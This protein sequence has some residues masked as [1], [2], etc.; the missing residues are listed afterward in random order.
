MSKQL[1]V[2]IWSDIACPWCYVGK[3][4]FERALERFEHAPDV[5]VTWRAFELDP[6]APRVRNPQ[7]YA[8]RIAAKYGRT[9]AQAQQMVDRMVEIARADGLAMDFEHAKPGNTF[10]AHR[11]LQLALERGSQAAL[12]ERLFRGYLCEGRAIG[13]HD[14]LLSLATDVG[15]SAAEVSATLATDQYA[16]EVR[17][18]EAE[19]RAL[20][21]H[22]VPFFVLGNRYAI[23]GAQPTEPMLRALERAWSELPER[24]ATEDA[25][26]GPDGCAT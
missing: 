5:A 23:E 24:I 4:R 19:A 16:R 3:R 22:G 14:T 12:E 25:I 11:L 21:I 26:C 17:A 1:Q 20:G 8:E 2:Q 15:L 18:D 10:D 13:E 9:P 6:S 7:P